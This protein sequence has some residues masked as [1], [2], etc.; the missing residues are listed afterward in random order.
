MI[1][2]IRP[3]AA[4]RG[5]KQRNPPV[6]DSRFLMFWNYDDSWWGN[7]DARVLVWR[8]FDPSGHH[9]ADVD[10]V[11]HSIRVDTGEKPFYKLLRRDIHLEIKGSRAFV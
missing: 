5:R 8:C 9:E 3:R 6:I 1:L 7:R 4:E 2:L 10:T 11:F